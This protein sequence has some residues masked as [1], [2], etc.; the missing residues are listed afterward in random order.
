M[1]PLQET[2]QSHPMI[3]SDHTVAMNRTSLLSSTLSFDSIESA[4][5]EFDSFHSAQLNMIATAIEKEIGSLLR[6]L[7]RK[8]PKLHRRLQNSSFLVK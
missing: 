4:D 2:M 5:V 8:H 3:S 6:C 1:Q 7:S